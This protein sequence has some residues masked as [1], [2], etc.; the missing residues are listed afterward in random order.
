MTRQEQSRIATTILKQLGGNRFKTMTGAK[1]FIAD[2]DGSLIFGL[3]GRFQK[4]KITLTPADVYRMVFYQIRKVGG[5]LR[6]H[7]DI[8]DDV[9]CDALAEVF[10][11]VTGLRTRLFGGG[12]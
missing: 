2:T 6:V 1:N 11:R 12:R 10:E 4:V 8:H 9:Y 7:E 5:V 3:T